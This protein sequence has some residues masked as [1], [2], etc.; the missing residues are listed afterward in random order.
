M[1]CTRYGPPEVLVQRD[2]VKPVPKDHEVLIR[3]H[4]AAVT[5]SD[6]YVRSG[7]VNLLLWLPMRIFVGFRRPR[8]PVLG[9][10]LA[11]E[12]E[13]TG[14][15]VQRFRKGDQVM[16]FTGKRFGAYAEFICLPE[17]GLF[18]PDE[19]ILAKKPSGLSWEEA[20]V[21]P[22]RGM[23]ALYFLKKGK[24]QNGQNV[25][26][27][28]ASGGVGTFAVQ[29]ARALGADVTGVCSTRN[30]DL[31]RSLGAGTVID[32]T[33]EKVIPGNMRYDLVFDAV[34]KGKT[35]DL[36]LQCQR[37]LA[38]GGKYLSVEGERPKIPGEYLQSLVEMI[39]KGAI[40][41]VID[42]RYPLEEIAVA[43]R[44]V[45][46]GHKQGNVVVIMEQNNPEE[47]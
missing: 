21:V 1:V 24:I 43:H 35:S 27:Y 2:V 12:I 9:L 22:T 8:N 47:R 33:R 46:E 18:M 37:A 32:Y 40:T 11:G 41:P 16:A 39:E 7:T 28:G 3:I 42:R 25:L 17:D 13:A 23:L 31:V 20:A 6:C 45:E 19:S 30:L 34:G 4:A 44:Y 15:N 5:V 29:L 36:K 14:K 10:E 26:I 38:P